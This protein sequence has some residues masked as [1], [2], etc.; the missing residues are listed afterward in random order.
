MSDNEKIS[1][2]IILPTL[3]EEKSVRKVIGSI[4]DSVKKI[5]EVLV[6]DGLSIDNTVEE[7]KAAGARVVMEKKRGKGI[8]MRTGADNAKGKMLIFL[9]CDN[10]HDPQKIPEFIEKLNGSNMVV[11]NFMHHFRKNKIKNMRLYLCNLF[12]QTLYSFYGIKMENPLNGMRAVW[13]ED[14]KR[15]NLNSVGFEIE[16]EMNVKSFVNNFKIDRVNLIIR[17]RIGKETFTISLY[18]SMIIRCLDILRRK[19]GPDR[20]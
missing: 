10:T 20:I 4:P 15:L 6:V 9:D 16:T 17:D 7:A 1:V 2:S 8:A 5:S 18:S 13:K 3:N 19:D 12:Y 11:G 14:M